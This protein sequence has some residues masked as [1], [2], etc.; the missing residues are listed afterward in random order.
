MEATPAAAEEAL[1][2]KKAAYFIVRMPICP[3]DDNSLRRAS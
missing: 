2:V 1:H 3:A